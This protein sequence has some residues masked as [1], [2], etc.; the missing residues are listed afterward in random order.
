MT[1]Q[2]TIDYLYQATPAFEQKGGSAYKPGLERMLGMSEAVGNPHKRLRCIHIAGTNGKGSVSSTLHSIFMEAGL[3][4]GLFTSPHL[5]SFRE[6]IRINGVPIP[7]EEV[8]SFVE[9]SLPL[10]ECWKPSFFEITTLM[11]FSY[12]V[13]EQVDLAIIEVGMG[14]RLDSTNIIT[15]LLGVITNVSFDHTQFLGNTLSEIA[16][17]KAGIMKPGVPMVIGEESDCREVFSAKARLVGCPLRYASELRLGDF[18]DEGDRLTLSDSPYGKLEIQLRG[19]SQLFN[20][21]TILAALRE[22]EARKL[23]PFTLENVQRGF[24]KVV[25]NSHLLGRWQ[26]VGD[27]PSVILD[28]GHNLAGIA[29]NCRQLAHEHF[30]RLHVV[31][32]MVS[33]KAWQKV[34]ELLPRERA[35]YYFAMPPCER[36]LPAETIQLY[37]EQLSLQGRA[38][39]TVSEAYRQACVEATPDDFIYVGGSNYIVAA[40]IQNFYP[41]LLEKTLRNIK[42]N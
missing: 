33:D 6:R 35:C 19:E 34:L 14:G 5:V 29:L 17:E 18:L 32:G 7:E 12:F 28:T 24:A 16:C 38:Y 3:R 36:G 13:Q 15:P 37:A 10:I 21:R 40:V 41:E 9:K 42:N 22:I 30:D 20:T 39:P 31:F 25:D 2:E 8:I 27:R 4:V 1:Y 26:R 11:A 23:L